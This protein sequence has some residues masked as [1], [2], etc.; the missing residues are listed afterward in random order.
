M[1]LDLYYVDNWSFWSDLAI[2]AKTVPT[3]LLRRGAY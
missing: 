3:V 1:R 2:V